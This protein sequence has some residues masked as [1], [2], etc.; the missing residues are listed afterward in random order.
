MEFSIFVLLL[1][2]FYFLNL[3]LL[4]KMYYLLLLLLHHLKEF[5][6]MAILRLILE[7]QLGLLLHHHSNF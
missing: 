2:L 4:L 3:V 6:S 1:I 7:I 5:L